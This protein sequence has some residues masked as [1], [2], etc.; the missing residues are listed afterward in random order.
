M[1]DDV[2]VTTDTI[3]RY[4]VLLNEEK[5][6][7]GAARTFDDTFRDGFVECKLYADDWLMAR[8]TDVYDDKEDERKASVET[9]RREATY[10]PAHAVDCIKRYEVDVLDVLVERGLVDRDNVARPF[11][12]PDVNGEWRVHR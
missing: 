8:Y 7:E 5:F 6:G 11:G 9:F 3:T 12:D 10:Y 4:R 2:I 1:T